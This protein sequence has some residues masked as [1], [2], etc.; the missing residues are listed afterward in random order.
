MAFSTK[1]FGKQMNDDCGTSPALPSGGGVAASRPLQT[2]QVVKEP[3]AAEISSDDRDGL[4]LKGDL[5]VFFYSHQKDGISGSFI[6][7]AG[8]PRGGKFRERT[9]DDAGRDKNVSGTCG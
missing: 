3:G 6:L 5:R 7:G 2:R 8:L 9:V 1:V 4:A